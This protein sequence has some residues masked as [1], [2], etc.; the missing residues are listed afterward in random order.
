MPRLRWMI[1]TLRLS[2]F[3]ITINDLDRSIQD[4][5]LPEVRD[6]FQS[7]ADISC[8]KVIMD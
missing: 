2:I 7:R 5:A 1:L 6:R 4:A 3:A 8:A